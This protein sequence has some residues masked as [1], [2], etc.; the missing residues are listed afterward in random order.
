MDN[1]LV[2]NGAIEFFLAK[3]RDKTSSS[4][5]CNIY[6]EN[7][8]IFLAGALSNYLHTSETI[9]ATPLG[10]KKCNLIDEEVV[11]IPVMRAGIA[12]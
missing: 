4:Y 9:I 11:L 10:E 5:E 7:I 8:S 12:M 3:F 6:V 1:V 2:Q